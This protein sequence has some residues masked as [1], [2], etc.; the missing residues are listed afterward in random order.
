MPQLCDSNE[1]SGDVKAVLLLRMF[2]CCAADG[3]KSP[4]EEAFGG[5]G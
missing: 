5:Y 4:A 1:T 2:P 3:E